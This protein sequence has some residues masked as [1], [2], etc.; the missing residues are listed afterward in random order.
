VFEADYDKIELQN[1]VMM[2]FQWCHHHYVIKIF[3]FGSLPIK[4]SGYGCGLG[5]MIWW[6]LKKAVL[7]PEKVVMVL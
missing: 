5:L 2:S 7:C 4:I 3:Q 1:I 6:S